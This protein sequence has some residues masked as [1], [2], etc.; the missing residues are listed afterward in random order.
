MASEPQRRDAGFLLSPSG[1][2]AISP[3]TVTSDDWWRLDGASPL[4][5]VC[6]GSGAGGGAHINTRRSTSK[7]V[8]GRPMDAGATGGAASPLLLSGG[9]VALTCSPWDMTADEHSMMSCA[10]MGLVPWAAGHP[11]GGGADEVG[12]LGAPAD[13]PFLTLPPSSVADVAAKGGTPPQPLPPP[14]SRAAYGAS[15]AAAYAMPAA[16]P[17]TDAGSDVT[18]FPDPSPNVD[19][20]DAAAAGTAGVSRHGGGVVA[21]AADMSGF[22]ALLGI[23]PSSLGGMAPPPALPAMGPPSSMASVAAVETAL[24]VAATHLPPPQAPLPP[25]PAALPTSEPLPEAIESKVRELEQLFFS[26][27]PMAPPVSKLPGADPLPPPPPPP[28]PLWQ[29][30]APLGATRCPAAGPPVTTGEGDMWLVNPRSVATTSGTASGAAATAVAAAAFPWT[31]P[32]GGPLVPV[33]HVESEDDAP[34]VGGG[35]HGSDADDDRPLKRA[36]RSVPAPRARR[37]RVG[38]SGG[39]NKK[40][41]GDVAAAAAAAAAAATAASTAAA[42]KHVAPPTKAP[43]GKRTASARVPPA[44]APGGGPPAGRPAPAKARLVG[45]AAR[46]AAAAGSRRKEGGGGG[47]TAATGV[48]AASGAS[49]ADMTEEELKAMRAEKNRE[50]ARRSRAKIKEKVAAMEARLIDLSGENATLLALMESL[51]PE[52]RTPPSATDP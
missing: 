51:M 23:D 39:G 11:G 50:S 32:N 24:V 22:A 27:R 2:A 47:S 48:S 28:P 20:L 41:K 31:A 21:N 19:T 43:R 25:P 12:G 49:T 13:L 18:L 40:K 3:A 6:G 42:V 34:L 29:L 16:P 26:D 10:G 14:P 36:K 9:G 30:T 7:V 46:S 38:G 44:A 35:G 15:K 4:G 33:T 17:P 5:D 52:G 37:T 8:T 1:D 45:A